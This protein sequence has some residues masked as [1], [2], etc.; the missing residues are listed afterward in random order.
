MTQLSIFYGARATRPTVVDS[1]DFWEDIRTGKWEKEIVN[2]RQILQ[3][4]GKEAYNEKKKELWAITMSGLF[5]GRSQDSMVRYSGYIQGDIDSVDNPEQLR[6][7]LAL[8]PHVRASFLSPSG[9]GVKLAIRVSDD[10][11]KHADSFHA[12]EK[13]FL[14]KHKVKLDPSCKDINRICFT[15][16]DPEIKGNED[17]IPIEVT[18][19][20]LLTILTELPKPV[21]YKYGTVRWN[22]VFESQGMVIKIIKNTLVVQC[23]WKHLH[24]TGVDGDRSTII[25]TD[26]SKAF[27][28]SHAHCVNRGPRDLENYFSHAV[29]S[30]YA[31]A[32]DH[33]QHTYNEPVGRPRKTNLEKKQEREIQ[34]IPDD[35]LNPP[36]F[37]GDWAKF[38]TDTAWFPQ[39]ELALGASLAFTATMLGRK[40]RDESDIRPNIYVAALGRTGIGKEHAR[41]LTKLMFAQ[42]GANGFGA[43]KLSSRS[44]IERT[45]SATPSCLYM[46]D[47]FGHY[48]SSIMNPNSNSHLRDVSSMFLELYGSSSSKFFGTDMA[49]RKGDTERFEIDQPSA[50]IYGTSTNES[51]WSSLTSE[52]VSSGTLNRFCIFHAKDKR[53]PVQESG[54]IGDIP[55]TLTTKVRAYNDMPVNPGAKGNVAELGIPKPQVIRSSDAAKVIFRKFQKE[56]LRLSD[57]G[58][59]TSSMWVRAAETAKKF[60]LILAGSRFTD[61]TAED[62]EYGCALTNAIIKNACVAIRENL[63]DNEYERESK[64]VETLIRD[65]GP[66]GIT[67]KDLVQRTRFL[68]SRLHRKALL[69]DLYES[70]LVNKEERVLGSSNKPSIVWFSE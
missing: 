57:R 35:M 16:W 24:S 21:Q 58:A 54:L 67:M 4:K 1:E 63:S 47:E 10:P 70:E 55:I 17:A 33:T 27:K 62:A 32:Y 2:L 6:D 60:A 19:P 11:E 9:K 40:I 69:E 26:G 59:D 64:R 34:P 43:E 5:R 36:G 15:S 56:T 66:K 68:K 45:I 28:C 44:A 3:G 51:F 65:C 29:V 23:P 25:F 12:A 13:Y 14:E 52:A 7:D 22:E 39:P 49:N 50:S 42:T 48:I 31:E 46:I 37:V 20:T 38:I 53:P 30:K 41:K 8:D 61:I 18:E